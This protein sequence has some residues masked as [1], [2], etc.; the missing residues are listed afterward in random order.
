MRSSS[1]RI[2]VLASTYPAQANDGT[3]AFVRD[4]SLQLAQEF[5]VTVLVPHVQG[6]PDREQDGPLDVRRFR[7]FPSRW[8]D[9]AEGA[10]LENLRSRKSRWLQV[11]PFF[12]ASFLAT[13]RALREQQVD[14]VHAHWII[15]QGIVA[16]IAIGGHRPLVLTTLGGDLYALTSR[17]LTAL[18][19]WIVERAQLVTVMN[20]DM[21][22]QAE[23][24]GARSVEVAPMGADLTT[25][26]AYPREPRP[27]GPPRLLFVGRLVEKKGLSV[28][29]E[30]LRAPELADFRLDV[31]GDGPL[32]TSLEEEARGL[33]VTFLGQLGRT[34]LAQEYARHE[35]VVVP[36]VPSASGDQDGLPVAMLEAM[37][38]GCA[39]VASDLPGINEA[40]EPERSGILVPPG[41]SARL[42]RELQ[43]AA[44]PE[45]LQTLSDGAHARAEY[46][47]VDA[48]GRRYRELIRRALVQRS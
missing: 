47:S 26:R 10:I 38:A 24:L 3:P 18:K 34:E 13:R 36:S 45:V 30:A 42:A 21:A 40:V 9:L 25:V 12:A 23:R 17:P 29:L 16:R 4:L 11:A 35:I 28:L 1:P 22:E 20:Q 37:G 31:V 44:R 33:N 46:L 41:D 27:S 14:V 15:P 2:L 48:V 6:A 43:R 19:R 8:E 7:Y 5:E 32:L 39:V